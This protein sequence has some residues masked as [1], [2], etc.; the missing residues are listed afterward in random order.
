MSGIPKAAAAAIW[1]KLETVT[2]DWV[3]TNK[4]RDI[5][6]K[7]ISDHTESAA[8]LTTYSSLIKPFTETHL[9]SKYLDVPYVVYIQF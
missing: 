4:M 5:F 7:K 3:E 9:M 8:S 2:P 6:F 1:S